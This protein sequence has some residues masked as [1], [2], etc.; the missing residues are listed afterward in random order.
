M[1]INQLPSNKKFGFTMSA[2]FFLLSLLFLFKELHSL[3]FI[4]V[5]MMS[6]MLAYS[7]FFPSKLLLLNK[8]WVKLGLILG[9]IVSPIVL[10]LIFFLLISP[11]A[12]IARFFGRDVLNLKKNDAT[13]FWK[14]VDDYNYDDLFDDQF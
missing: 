5:V 7:I 14:D 2:M 1:K 11:I 10:G 8:L 9:S 13:T 12:F 6:L 3:F 4:F